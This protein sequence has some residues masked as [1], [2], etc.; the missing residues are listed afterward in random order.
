MYITSDLLKPEFTNTPSNIIA[1]KKKRTS[2]D[3]I[4]R[5]ISKEK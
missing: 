3:M 1:E 5:D 4:K 2:Y